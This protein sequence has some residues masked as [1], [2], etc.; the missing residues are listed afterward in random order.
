MKKVLIRAGDTDILERLSG[1][2]EISPGFSGGIEHAAIHQRSLWAHNEVEPLFASGGESIYEIDR[3]YSLQRVDGTINREWRITARAGD[4]NSVRLR[5]IF[6]GEMK[7]VS[8]V[9]HHVAESAHCSFAVQSAREMLT[10]V[11]KEGA[12]M[13][14]CVLSIG[15]SFLYD[16]L[17]LTEDDLPS[18]LADAWRRGESVI[19]AFPVSRNTLAKARQCM[20]LRE[21]GAWDEVRLRAVA[22]DLLHLVFS[23][24]LKPQDGGARSVRLTDEDHAK[25][26]AIRDR[27]ASRYPE[28]ITADS[29]C[30]E[31][32]LNRNKLHYGFKHVFGQS[33]HDHLVE[34]R[35]R[36][37]AELLLSTDLAVSEIAWRVGFSEPTNFTAAFK[38]Y[39]GTLPSRARRAG[40]TAPVGRRRGGK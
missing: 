14:S 40:P 24:W 3:G 12:V 36:K 30:R 38:R 17:G 20:A 2:I 27:V 16:M 37:A 23:D 9:D 35:M 32:A 28:G 19:G 13:R 11:V 18:T 4:E 7:Y 15:E 8:S 22:Y 5:M 10:V 26:A 33:L 25:L 29:L 6:A 34:T 31:F 1:V 21:G 39:F